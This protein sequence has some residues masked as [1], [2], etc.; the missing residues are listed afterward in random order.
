MRKPQSS[1][2]S[3]NRPE[4]SSSTHNTSDL[5][6]TSN[7]AN[8]EQ[9]KKSHWLPPRVVGRCVTS[10]DRKR[11]ISTVRFNCSGVALARSL[12]NKDR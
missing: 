2:L 7:Q 1:M 11:T 3:N 4:V 12:K 5:C 8:M 6:L 10:Q 9:S